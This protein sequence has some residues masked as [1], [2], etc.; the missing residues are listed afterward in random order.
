MEQYSTQTLACSA[1]TGHKDKREGRG[2]RMGTQSAI[3][4]YT[5]AFASWSTGWRALQQRKENTTR[6]KYLHT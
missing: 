5:S 3:V 6:Y 1:T 2:L 4:S